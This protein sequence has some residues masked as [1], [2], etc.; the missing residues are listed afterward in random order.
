MSRFLSRRLEDFSAY[1]A[2]MSVRDIKERYGMKRVVKMASNE[3]PLGASPLVQKAVKAHADTVFRYARPG[4]PRLTKALA[5]HHGLA[6]EHIVCGNGSDEIIDL[7]VRVCADAGEHNIVAFSPCF[8]MY[9]LMAKLCGVEFRQTPLRDDFTQPLDEL[10]SFCD[11]KTALCFVTT[12]DNPSGYAPRA[13][14]LADLAAKLPRRCLLVLDEAYMDFVAVPKR[15][16]LLHRFGDFDNVA[17][18]RTFSKM[19]GLAGLRLGY[20]VL[21]L[22][23]ADACLRVKPPFSVNVL[24][25]EAGLAAL[26]DE[27]FREAVLDTV[28]SGRDYLEEA[29]SAMGCRVYPSLAN[30]IMFALPEDA[31]L[32]AHEVFES[33]LQRG[34]IIRP[35]KS[36]GMPQGFRVSIGNMEENKLFAETLSE[37]LSV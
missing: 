27:D 6:P 29:L 12:P 17:V 28:N 7:L 35:L 14:E 15:Y 20:G 23:V 33:M 16:S 8:S 11:E 19:Y 9:P 26:Q 31:K 13:E 10:L 4:N 24:A 34:V 37:V 21:P 18:L 2:G 36:Y 5:E 32:K 1:V 3:N 25:Q 22:E 30:Y